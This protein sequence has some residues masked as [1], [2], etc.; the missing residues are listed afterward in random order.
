MKL[1]S[2]MYNTCMCVYIHI[3]IY[4]YIH[5]HLGSPGGRGGDLDGPLQVAHGAAPKR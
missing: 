1:K 5:T 3:Y 4:I 2:G